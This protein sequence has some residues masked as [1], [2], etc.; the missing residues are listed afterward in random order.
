MTIATTHNTPFNTGSL[1]LD[2]SNTTLIVTPEQFDILC[3]DN[4]DLRL[5]LTRNREL[6]VMSPTGGETGK[7]NGNLFARVWNWNELTNLGETFDSSTGYDFTAI[8]GGKLSPDVSWI[9][10]SRLEGVNIVGF[11]PVVPDFAIE[12]RSATDR[13]SAVRDKMIEY[14]RLGVRLGLLV[15][16]QDR[17]VEIYRLGQAVEVLESPLSISC[18]DVMPGFVLSLSGIW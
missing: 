18:E 15:N 2:V 10:K 5:E 9:E 4:P 11:I 7:K 17:K 16:P 6:I 8:D 13:L 12:L 1:L 3:A 14:Q